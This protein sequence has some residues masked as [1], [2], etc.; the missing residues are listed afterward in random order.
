[1][2]SA[3]LIL[4][5]LKAARALERKEESTCKPMSIG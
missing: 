5:D 4:D 1:M 2:K 3:L